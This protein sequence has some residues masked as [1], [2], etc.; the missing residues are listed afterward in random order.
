MIT[1]RSQNITEP[2]SYTDTVIFQNLIFIP[3]ISV[4][5]E[6]AILIYPL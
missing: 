4:Y 1:L 2:R 3:K 6:I 5:A